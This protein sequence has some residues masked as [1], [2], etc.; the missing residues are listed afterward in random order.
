[1]KH[2]L[3]RSLTAPLFWPSGPS[4]FSMVLALSLVGCAAWAKL[5]PLVDAMIVGSCGP[6]VAIVSSAGGAKGPAAGDTIARVC[7]G[8]APVVKSLVDVV[9]A[10]A[11]AEADAAGAADLNAT[12]D[13]V[14]SCDANC[15]KA[16]AAA[17]AGGSEDWLE[18]HLQGAV[19]G[20]AHPVYH[21][22]VEPRLLALPPADVRAAID[23]AALLRRK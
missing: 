18:L 6:L 12:T 15:P 19:V 16:S 4:L 14:S 17:G 7:P 5:Q 23:Q 21:K 8:V 3:R 9:S 20:Y 2:L 13:C 22:H 10:L 11:V 1:M